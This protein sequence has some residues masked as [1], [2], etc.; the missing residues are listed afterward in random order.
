MQTNN[1]SY[2][3]FTIKYFTEAGIEYVDE[4][5]GAERAQAICREIKLK[6]ETTVAETQFCTF[7]GRENADPQRQLANIMTLEVIYG[8]ISAAKM[9][10]LE[11]QLP[12]G[13]RTKLVLTKQDVALKIFDFYN[14]PLRME[15]EF[16]RSEEHTS[17][18]QSRP[19]LVCRLLL[20]NKNE[21]LH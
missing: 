17:E 1:P 14:G 13:H 18:L 8:R 3:Y 19:H 15:L 20:E 4:Y 21:L 5:M 16:P 9:R 6:K 11:A 7:V 10:K 12:E 2:R